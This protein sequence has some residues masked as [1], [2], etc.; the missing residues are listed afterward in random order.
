ME[1]EFAMLVGG[2]EAYVVNIVRQHRMV[3]SDAVNK[4]AMVNR[5][6]KGSLLRNAEDTRLYPRCGVGKML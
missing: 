2:A 6:D 3:S 1:S 5:V 4:E